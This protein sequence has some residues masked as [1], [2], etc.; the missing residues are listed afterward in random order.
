MLRC[1]VID[2]ERPSLNK[3][4]KL[5]EDSGMV[6]LIGSFINPYE[7][8]EFLKENKADAIFLDIEMPGIS[9][10]ELANDVIELQE[11]ASIVFVTAYNQYALEAFRLNALDYIMKPVSANQLEETLHKLIAIKGEVIQPGGLLIRC[12]GK[13]TVMKG[14]DEV[15]FRTEKAEQLLA[16]MVD[17]R[18]NFISRSEIIDNLWADFDGERALIHFNT[19]L[20]YVKKAL[21]PYDIRIPFSYDRGGYQ[22]DSSDLHCDYL[23]L[24]S[25][26]DQDRTISPSNVLEFEEVTSLYIGE[27]LAG[28]EYD[29]VAVKRLVL[30]ERFLNMTVELAQFYANKS[31]YQKARQWLGRGLEIEPLHR[32]L[33]YT[34]I[35]F[36]LQLHEVVLA[37][38]YYDLYRDGLHTNL[39]C[40]PDEAFK[41]LLK[42]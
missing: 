42:Q 7:G 31:Q 34:M 3:L 11:R 41:Q 8:L 29:W 23:R 33:N 40:E 37:G 5:L 2:D 16:F 25:F 35:E 27:Y 13:F 20:H 17:R 10:V 21:L 24:S 18:N 12:F 38:N 28:W 26:L 9:G 30:K 6:E 15:K 4:V 14:Q 32:E 36:L 1:V 19:T 22:F 39:G